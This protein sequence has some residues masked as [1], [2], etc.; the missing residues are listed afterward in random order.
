MTAAAKSSAM[1][2]MNLPAISGHAIPRREHH[3]NDIGCGCH[4]TYLLYRQ[5]VKALTHLNKWQQ[6]LLSLSS[7]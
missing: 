5:H 6:A 2:R 4:L 3:S 1:S 7:A